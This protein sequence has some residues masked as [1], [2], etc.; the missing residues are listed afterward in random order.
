MHFNSRTTLLPK[1]LNCNNYHGAHSAP[2]PGSNKSG[3]VQSFIYGPSGC[4]IPQIRFMH[5][6]KITLIVNDSPQCAL[7]QTRLGRDLAVRETA[8]NTVGIHILLFH[9]AHL[10]QRSLFLSLSRPAPCLQPTPSFNVP[11]A[12]GPLERGVIR[13]E[14]K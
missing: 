10:P 1:M 9:D 3:L 13:K 12:V 7:R 2:L 11:H 4:R 5:V 8:P 14:S 6:M